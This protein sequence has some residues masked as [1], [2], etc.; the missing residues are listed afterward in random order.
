[1]EL[2]Y[3]SHEYWRLQQADIL[4]KQVVREKTARESLTHAQKLA[5]ENRPE[6]LA[7]A[8]TL[9]RN[10]APDT[11]A[12]EEAEAALKQWSQSLIIVGLEQWQQGDQEG[13]LATVQA[14]PLHLDLP[15]E[16]KDLIQIGQAMQL[17]E[18]SLSRTEP[19]PS[20]AQ[21]WQLMEAVSATQS[22][23]PSSPFY[24]DAQAVMHTWQR[25]LQDLN[26]LL[27]ANT[28]AGWG[29]RSALELAIARADQVATDR[30]RR[31]QAQTLIAKWQL[32]VQSLE[33]QP[34]LARAERWTRS[35]E[36]SDLK[37]AI[38]QVKVIPS[39]R[40][41]WAKA[42]QFI[43]EWTAQIQTIED[44]PFWDQAQKLAKQGKL[45]EAIDAAAKIQP[46]RALYAQ[47]QAGITAWKG[48]IQAAEIAADQPILDRAY[49][50]A[51]RQRLSM[52]IDVASQI[53]PGRALYAEA[54]AAISAWSKE[55]D[56]LW[57]V[58]ADEPVP[59]SEGVT[60]DESAY[61]DRSD[62]ETN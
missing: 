47:A 11:Y 29:D 9:V 3:L 62:G 39:D 8:I 15:A 57:K 36:I 7:E 10:V 56:F 40:P 50:L 17:A 61:D 2:G 16:G 19:L 35:G 59:A 14:I 55:R 32:A 23:S 1:V 24:A 33:D 42:Q 30:P 4:F 12:T 58:W 53:A 27:V 54:Q 48:E 6:K 45:R 44:Q 22:I 31:L 20:I 51:A 21:V 60:V 26:Q 13:A 41:A 37:A 5:K 18:I 34:F 49:G 38:A 25:H 46:N 43:A 28:I 52:A